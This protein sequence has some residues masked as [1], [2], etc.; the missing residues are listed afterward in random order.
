MRLP[1][2]SRERFEE[3]QARIKELEDK[4]NVLTER[5][6]LSAEKSKSSGIDLSEDDLSK[7]KPIAGRPTIASIQA[8][9][10]TAAYRNAQTPGAKSLAVQLAEHA[11]VWRQ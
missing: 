8:E 9:A 11:K 3:A 5:L 1:F 4:N 10:N 6:I 2:V 7:I